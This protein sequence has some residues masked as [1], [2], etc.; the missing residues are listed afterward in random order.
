M[1][2]D[3]TLFY[4][5]GDPYPWETLF[6][7]M[8]ETVELADELGFH[9]AVAGRTPLCLGR[10]VPLGLQPAAAGCRLRALQR[11]PALSANAA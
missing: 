2:F 4:H 8:H 9:R 11:P 10:L 6:D 7:E 5:V 1:R 3:S